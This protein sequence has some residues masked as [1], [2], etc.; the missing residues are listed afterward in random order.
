MF[1]AGL[2]TF[3]L[4]K[5]FWIVDH[6]FFEFVGFWG[7]FALLVRWIGRGTSEYLDKECN[8]SGGGWNSGYILC[9]ICVLAYNTL[10]NS[11]CALRA[12]LSLNVK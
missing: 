12:M 4:S 5:E 10:Q 8:V 11:P 9:D 6:G 7:A 1:G 3:L 2:V